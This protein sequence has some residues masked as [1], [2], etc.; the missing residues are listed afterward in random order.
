MRVHKAIH[1]SR[2]ALKLTP[3][4]FICTNRVT[5]KSYNLRKRDIFQ[6]M[7]HARQFFFSLDG[8]ALRFFVRWIDCYHPQEDSQAKYGWASR[9]FENLG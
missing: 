4:L 6:Q 3:A 9:A 7:R 8:R 2:C 1:T 5:V